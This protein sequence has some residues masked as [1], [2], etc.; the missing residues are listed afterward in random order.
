MQRSP[1]YTFLGERSQLEKAPYSVI[2]ILCCP[3]KGRASEVPL[4]VMEGWRC[5]E[6]GWRDGQKGR[7]PGFLKGGNTILYDITL[8][9]TC[10]N[11]VLDIHRLY[12]TSD[13][14]QLVCG[15][16]LHQ[17]DKG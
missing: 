14:L 13:Q 15:I 5:Q 11:T 17:L 10:H 9:N 16:V 7:A 6:L 8:V 2:P 12:V 1:Y 3:G 4:E